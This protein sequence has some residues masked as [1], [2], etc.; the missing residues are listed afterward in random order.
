MTR[1]ERK[2]CGCLGK[3][4][5]GRRAGEANP[6]GSLISGFKNQQG[7]LAGAQELGEG[8]R[9][10]SRQEI[11]G[12]PSLASIHPPAVALV[13]FHFHLIR[14]AREIQ[15]KL[16]SIMT[17]LYWKSSSDSP[18]LAES[19]PKTFQCANKNDRVDRRHWWVGR[20]LL[21]WH[22]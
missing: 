21:E 15:L 18:L 22:L 20:E 4:G 12:H 2:P 3:S 19:K 17:L 1:W 10:R 5:A 13:L 8:S 9:K 11:T 7:E 14:A 6:Y 16:K